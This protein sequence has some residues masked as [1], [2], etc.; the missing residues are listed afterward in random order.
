MEEK[1]D[2]QFVTVSPQCPEGSDW[3][4]GVS[5]LASLLDAILHTHAVDARRVYLTGI[6]MGGNGVWRFAL[7]CPDRFAALAPICGYGV[8]SRGF[9]Q[10]VCML[11]D[12]PIWIFHGGADRI[13][14]LQESKVIHDVLHDCGTKVRLTIYPECGHDA[15][16]ETYENPELYR[17]FLSHS[18][19]GR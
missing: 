3:G 18:L 5:G 17:W 19:R 10:S 7:E 14:P 6:S 8:H 12:I 9:R 4:S 16:T 1:P 2:F 15:W 11:K 13:V